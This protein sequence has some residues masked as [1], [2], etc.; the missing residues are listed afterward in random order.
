MSALGVNAPEVR[1]V[2]DRDAYRSGER[3]NATVTLRG[4]GA[5][6]DAYSRSLCQR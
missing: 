2:L 4:G 3:V 6:I 1:T 5:D